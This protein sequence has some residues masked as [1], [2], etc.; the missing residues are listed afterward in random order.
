[1]RFVDLFAGA[2][3]LSLGLKQAGHTPVFAAEQNPHALATYR[4]NLG[5]HA[6]DLDIATLSPESI[7]RRAGEID[8]VVGGPP[9]QGFSV[10]RRGA[11][12]DDRNGLVVR[13]AELAVALSPRFIL[14]EN[15][16]SVRG[17]GRR[18]LEAFERVTSASYD[19]AVQ[20][21]DAADYGVAQ[22]RRRAF[23]VGWRKG[24]RPFD[25][26]S[27]TSTP[28]TVRDALADL[29]APPTDYRPHPDFPNHIRARITAPNIER[30]R[31]VPEGG[32]RLDIPHE[33]QLPCHRNAG[34]HRHLDV[35]GRM[36]WDRPAPTLTAM[37]DNFS[38]GRF[39]HPVQDR[40]ITGREGARLQGFP[41]SFV[42]EGPKKEVARQIGNA[43]PPPLARALGG[44]L[45]N[46]LTTT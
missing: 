6:H 21:L 32:G 37:F 34:T 10:Q 36:W 25:F 33:L 26:P 31:H 1:M 11:A 19:L 18:V 3:G 9:C 41:D 12:E 35:F 17:R 28:R 40:S 14:M 43:V 5:E 29:P 39:A 45:E 15:V 46:S 44:A 4:K 20:V 27:P 24:S 7:R 2:G 23:V 8:L 22:H 13:F 42:F 38:R 16:P 30:I